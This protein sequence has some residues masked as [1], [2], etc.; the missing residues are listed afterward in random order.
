[1]LGGHPRAIPAQ[2]SRLLHTGG[3]AH[4]IVHLIKGDESNARC[5]YRIA[6][7]AFPDMDAIDAEVAALK[8]D[9]EKTG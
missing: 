4:G 3:R 6:G 2:R 5:W 7:R 1:M 9:W 8:A